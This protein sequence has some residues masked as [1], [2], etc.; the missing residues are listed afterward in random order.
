MPRVRLGGEELILRPDP[1]MPP[2]REG[3]V[4]PDPTEPVYSPDGSA[5]IG[6]R[7]PRA[8]KKYPIVAVYSADPVTRWLGA[9]YSFRLQVAMNLVAA[10]QKVHQHKCVVG[11]SAA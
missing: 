8:A 7:L 1:A 4:Y 11:D 2:G 5:L 10:V 6:C 3:A 9:D